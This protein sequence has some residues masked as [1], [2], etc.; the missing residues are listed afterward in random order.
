[1]KKNEKSIDLSNI[2]SEMSQNKNIYIQAIENKVVCRIL[3]Q[4][5]L[6]T[7]GGIIVP[8][9]ASTTQQPQIF[10]EVISVG[11]MVYELNPCE[12]IICHPH[13]G[14]DIMIGNEIIK[15]LKVEEIYGYLKMK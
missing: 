4:S 9:T 11:E 7:E 12:I 3:K 14:M 15:V 10:C 1:M 2:S 6:K 5:E 8:D 13:S